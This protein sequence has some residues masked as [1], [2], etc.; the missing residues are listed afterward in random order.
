LQRC[1]Q[2]RLVTRSD[3]HAALQ[4][5]GIRFW[6]VNQDECSQSSHEEVAEVKAIY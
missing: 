4:P 3:A 2:Q 6:P 1:E 5:V